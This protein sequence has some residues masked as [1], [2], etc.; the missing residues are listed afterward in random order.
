VLREPAKGGKICI[1]FH[2]TCLVLSSL[3]FFEAG[4]SAFARNVTESFISML[5]NEEGEKE[6]I[7][8]RRRNPIDF[9]QLS[10]QSDKLSAKSDSR[11]SPG[12]RK[13]NPKKQTTNTWPRFAFS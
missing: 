9:N 10:T 12:N 1:R 5:Q 2:P 13:K 7:Q 11:K 3:S 8:E 6:A 4:H